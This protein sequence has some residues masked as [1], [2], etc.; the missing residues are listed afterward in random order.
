MVRLHREAL[1]RG[2]RSDAAVRWHESVHTIHAGS[3]LIDSAHHTRWF[4][5]YR[6]CTPH[7]TR[8]FCSYRFCTPYML[9][10]VLIDSAHHTIHAVFC[11]YRFCTPHAG[12]VLIDSVNL[13]HAGK[14]TVPDL[15]RSTVLMGCCI[16]QK[17]STRNLIS[18]GSKGWDRFNMAKCSISL[19]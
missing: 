6:F 13:V 8:W 12:S 1:D 19:S 16:T 14:Y 5:S 17:L 9:F 18:V 10:S 4:C 11:S 2:T 7:H 15:Q 3:V